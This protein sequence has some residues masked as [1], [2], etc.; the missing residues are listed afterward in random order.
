MASSSSG[1]CWYSS[2]RTVWS[3]STNLAGSDRTAA[4]VARSSQSI[5]AYPGSSVI[6]PII[7]CAGVR[8]LHCRNP[9]G[10]QSPS[11]SHLDVADVWR[12]PIQFACTSGDLRRRPATRIR[13]TTSGLYGL[14]SRLGLVYSA[15]RSR[16]TGATCSKTRMKFPPMIPSTSSWLKPDDLRHPAIIQTSFSPR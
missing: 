6:S 12:R 5:P 14:A 3:A 11:R 15:S 10:I 16:L 4:R 13:N 2:I 1:T 7:F 8:R 9:I